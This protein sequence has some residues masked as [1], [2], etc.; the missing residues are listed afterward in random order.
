[1]NIEGI[2]LEH[3]STL[4]NSG[5]NESTKSCPH[6]ALF[7]YFLL[8]DSK[9]DAATTTSHSKRLIGLLKERKLLAS[10]LSTIWG[11]SDGCEVQYRCASALYLMSVMSQC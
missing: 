5:I 1:M 10:A 6:H 7:Q 9:Q 2:A 3:F 4:P 11:N 8:D